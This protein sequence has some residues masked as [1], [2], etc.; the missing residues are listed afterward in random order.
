[1][2]Q[3]SMFNVQCSM[4]NGLRFQPPASVLTAT[5]LL[6]AALLRA[7]AFAALVVRV[8]DAVLVRLG[9]SSPTELCALDG[10]CDVVASLVVHFRLHVLEAQLVRIGAPATVHSGVELSEHAQVRSALPLA[11]EGTQ[12][13]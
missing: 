6:T 11:T 10:C 13:R 3:P 9:L 12:E 5:A 7:A 1:M 2:R 8:A 4:F